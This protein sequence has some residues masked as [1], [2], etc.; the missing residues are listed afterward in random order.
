MIDEFDE[1]TK[2]YKYRGCWYKNMKDVENAY[3]NECDRKYD[4]Y[5]YRYMTEEA[6][7]I[8]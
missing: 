7:D 4:E 2:E 8:T 6:I 3:L 5:K 1:I